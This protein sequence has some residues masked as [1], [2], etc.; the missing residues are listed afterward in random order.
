[1]PKKVEDPCISY[2]EM[3]V[4]WSLIHD[5]CGGT[6]AM[7]AAGEVWLPREKKEETQN[8]GVRLGRSILYNGYRDTLEK[9]SSRPFSK[10][11]IVEKVPT[12]LEDLTWNIDRAGSDITTFAKT[13]FYTA[14]NYG[15]VHIFVDYPKMQ[16]DASIAEE[17]E[18]DAR[19]YLICIKPSELIGWRS[20]QLSNGERKLTRIR[21]HGVN[22]EPE[23]DWGDQQVETIRI[24]TT[25]EWAL[26]KKYPDDKEL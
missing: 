18:M 5:L 12:K 22:I 4:S 3:A 1:M 25:T 7:R 6:Q 2:D 21:L 11:V 26:Y 14:V 8:Y 10:P 19:P 16:L 23:G 13:L 15:L 9:L 20:I 17:T 24:Y